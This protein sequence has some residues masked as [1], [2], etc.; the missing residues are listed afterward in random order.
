MARPKQELYSRAE[1]EL[2]IHMATGTV[3]SS[4]NNM[5][6]VS[7]AK[8]SK[9][10]GEIIMG[11]AGSVVHSSGKTDELVKSL[12]LDE[13]RLAQLREVINGALK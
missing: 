5:L 7:G 1:V 6:L 12:Q 8:P 13:A 2:I 10:V 11:I 3:G 4:L 9:E